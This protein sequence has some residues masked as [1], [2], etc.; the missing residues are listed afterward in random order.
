MVN[1]TAVLEVVS[2]ALPHNTMIEER[3]SAVLWRGGNRLARV[4]HGSD[5]VSTHPPKLSTVSPQETSGNFGSLLSRVCCRNEGMRAVR[6]C[7]H[8]S[9]GGSRGAVRATHLAPL[10]HCEQLPLTLNVHPHSHPHSRSL[11]IFHARARGSGSI[12][13]ASLCCII[14]CSHARVKKGPLDG[15]LQITHIHKHNSH[16]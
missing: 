6:A 14:P 15:F 2:S 8:G 12:V 5:M 9:E 10:L 1:A 4:A 13:L 7:G 16:F 11:P 3:A